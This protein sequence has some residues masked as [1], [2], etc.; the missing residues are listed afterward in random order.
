[1]MHCSLDMQPTHAA[2]TCKTMMHCSL[3]MQFEHAN[4]YDYD[5]AYDL[6]LSAS[7]RHKAAVDQ[8]DIRPI[9]A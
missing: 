1:M 2:W 6:L 7:Y 9:E 3:D 8:I 4:D 5:Y